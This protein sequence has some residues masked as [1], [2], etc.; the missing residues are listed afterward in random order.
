MLVATL[1][2]AQAM[3]LPMESLEGLVRVDEQELFLTSAGLIKEER[4]G[5]FKFS[6]EKDRRKSDQRSGEC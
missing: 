1:R 2:I 4:R 3:G 5:Q 6:A